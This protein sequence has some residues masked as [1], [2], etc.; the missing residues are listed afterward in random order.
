MTNENSLYFDGRYYDAIVSSL[1]QYHD[2]DFY[3]EMA[4][5]YGGEILELGSGTGRLTIPIARAGFSISGLDLEVRFI[6]QAKI[7]ANNESLKISWI[8][9]D[10]D[11]FK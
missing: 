7:K 1:D 11:N 5:L 2:L 8:E 3:L 4:Q 10:M 9:G 6:E